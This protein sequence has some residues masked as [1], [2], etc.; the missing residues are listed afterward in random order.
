MGKE[1]MLS[2]L[3]S[4]QNKSRVRMGSKDG[5]CLFVPM[6]HGVGC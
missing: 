1:E 3:I 6:R 4:K 2:G 5:I